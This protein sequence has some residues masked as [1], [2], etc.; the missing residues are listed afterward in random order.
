MQ[1]F[2]NG[3]FLGQRRTGIQRFAFETLNA[4]DQLLSESDVYRNVEFIVVAPHGT[5]QPTL[6]VMKFC[7]V[8]PFRGHLWEQ[9]T[10]PAH[11]RGAFLIGFGATGPLAKKQ[12]VVT[13]HD[14]AVFVVPDAFGWAFR[15]WYR[16]VLP[17]LARRAERLMTVSE[18]AK[19]EL[20]RYLGVAASHACVT[21]EGWEHIRDVPAEPSVLANHCL[22]PGRYVLAVGSISPHKNLSVVARA[23]EL[24]GR[25][26]DI[27]F[28][29]AGPVNRSVFRQG[30]S[31]GSLKLIGYVSD[32]ELRA[33]YEHAGAFV[34]PSR[35]EGF[36][37]PPI[38]AMGLGCPVIASNVAA[39]P[40]VCGDAAWYFDPDDAPG[41]VRLIARMF[42]EPVERN[43]LIR[44][45]YA[46]AEQHQWRLA[47]ARFLE[48]VDEI[49]RETATQPFVRRASEFQQSAE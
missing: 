23:M 29:V 43:A 8:G 46:R 38:E 7:D 28:V 40:E 49:A 20:V 19:A 10:L 22:E 27:D 32:G 9:L 11:C 26:L 39:M 13:I 42:S 6:K 41:L 16:F 24:L 5:P 33:L 44:K 31:E 25:D 36:G 45:G 47:A 12:Q 34:H 21:G 37:I 17:V 30:K 15:Q 3:R 14:A 4:L 48:L 18:F 1:I 2:I 35:Y